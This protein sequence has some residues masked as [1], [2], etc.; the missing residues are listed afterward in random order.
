MT[1]I[2]ICGITN[3]TDAEAAVRAGADALG[4][5]FADSPRRVYPEELR[6]WVFD[7]PPFVLRVGVF[8]D[9]RLEELC[10]TLMTLCIDLVQLHGDES[11]QYCL[12]APQRVVKRLTV[13]DHD[14]P[15]SLAA[16]MAAYRGCAC[17]FLLDPGAGSGR[18][19][20]WEVARGRNERLIISGGLTPENVGQAVRTLRPYAVDVSSGVERKPGVKDEA[21]MRA[22][23]AAVR[24]A[25]ADH[26]A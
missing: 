10:D 11:P 21:K 3:P 6:R 16:R 15:S 5:V 19:F 26:A 24:N 2:K 25:D 9:Q 23:V 18:V 22:F 17:A 20:P 4:F 7:L 12:D 14:T 1:R 8:R 13:R